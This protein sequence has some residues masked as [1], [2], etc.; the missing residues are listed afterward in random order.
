[1]QDADRCKALFAEHEG[2]VL[3]YSRQ[4]ITLETMVSLKLLCLSVLSVNSLLC[5]SE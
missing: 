3:D 4:N 2:A 1:M 5:S